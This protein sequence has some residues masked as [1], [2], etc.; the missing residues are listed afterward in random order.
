[1]LAQGDPQPPQHPLAPCHPAVGG[2]VGTEHSTPH[3]MGGVG[4]VLGGWRSITPP[5]RMGD[6][7]ACACMCACMCACAHMC[8]QHVHGYRGTCVGASH[9]HVAGV[10]MG[11]RGHP[12]VH[13]RTCACGCSH[14]P[15]PP[16]LCQ[17]PHRQDPDNPDTHGGVMPL[18]T[19]HQGGCKPGVLAGGSSRPC[20]SQG[21]GR[22]LLVAAGGEVAR[23]SLV[24]VQFN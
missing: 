12:R 2:A 6:A 16:A 13:A 11:L 7:Y 9:T 24:R 8:R 18:P 14:L 15:A 20:P 17:A 23:L 4:R 10:G 22:G 19:P 5:W 1:M 21:P 3:W